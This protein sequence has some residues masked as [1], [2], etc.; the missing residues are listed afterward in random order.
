MSLFDFAHQLFDLQFMG[1]SLGL[2]LLFLIVIIAL[3]IFDL[4]FL[5]RKDEVIDSKTS[6]GYSAF[7]MVLASIFGAWL[8]YN[9]GEDHGMDYFTAY[10]IEL[11]LSLDNL[12][13]MSVILTFF[14]V[15]RKYQHRVL[16]W[17]IVGV[18]VMRGA[19]IAAGV[20]IV[21]S[22]SWA[23]YIFAAFLLVTGIKMLLIK[24]D[25]DDNIED[26]FLIRF[27]QKHLRFTKEIDGHKFFVRLPD[28]T[29]GKIVTF[30]TPLFMALICIEFM[31]VL[32]ALDSVPAVFA[33]TNEP[34]VIYTSNIFA[35]L[36]LRSMYFAVAA[37][38]ERFKYMKYALAIVLIFIGGKVFY[39]GMIGH[40]SPAIS[41]GI[42]LSVL[43]GGVLFSLSKTKDQAR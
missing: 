13:V 18:L 6:L 1:E 12:F 37:M 36:G 14:H 43:I 5:N 23:L 26:S 10:M 41:L 33:I 25:D 42:T 38:I 30:A 16:F 15:P 2:W 22:F 4:G 40:I 39:T 32:F 7:Y 20:V 9:M 21:Q 29:T 34:F 17:G 31:D 19:M 11:S 35:I 27:F 8:W 28:H 24:D 3:M